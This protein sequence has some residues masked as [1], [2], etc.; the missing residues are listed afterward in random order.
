M[1][2]VLNILKDEGLAKYCNVF[3]DNE[4]GFEEFLDL[5]DEHLSILNLPLGPKMRIKKLIQKIKKSDNSGKFQ[6]TRKFLQNH[7]NLIKNAFTSFF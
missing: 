7:I 3:A 1:S 5:E 6:I 4:I 2:T